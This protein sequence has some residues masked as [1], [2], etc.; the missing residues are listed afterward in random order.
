MRCQ[1][2][3]G[4]CHQESL[5]PT[6][7]SVQETEDDDGWLS[8][9]GIIR[10][11]SKTPEDRPSQVIS[12]SIPPSNFNLEKLHP[13]NK[14]TQS[15][16]INYKDN[17]GD[18]NNDISTEPGEIP[19]SESL[20][21][22]PALYSSQIVK[23]L[24]TFTTNNSKDIDRVLNSSTFNSF[25]IGQEIEEDDDGWLSKDSINQRQSK[26]PEDRPCSSVV[27]KTINDNDN[28]GDE[29]ADTSTEP[30]EIPPSDSESVGTE[31]GEIP[32]SDESMDTE[33]G[34]LPLSDYEV[35]D[36]Y[37]TGNKN[38]TTR[39]SIH[40]DDIEED[41]GWLAR[42]DERHADAVIVIRMCM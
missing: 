23:E 16:L 38:N 30:G 21:T 41:N 12:K 14:Q 31:P 24:S 10:Q 4:K 3:R 5:N 7:T 11:L 35:L 1:P 22:E 6:W 32:L 33:P 37:S 15:K 28:V 39:D 13:I 20:G 18:G 29:N 17:D 27:V 9:E 25:E 42:N 34:E 36:D 40:M 8:K 2:F 26:T 19:D